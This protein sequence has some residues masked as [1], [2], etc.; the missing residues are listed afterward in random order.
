MHVAR[1]GPKPHR[2]E[3]YLASTDPDLKFELQIPKLHSGSFFPSPLEPRRRID[4]ALLA[5]VQE[6]DVLGISSRRSATSWPHWVA[7]VLVAAR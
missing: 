7:A 3:R 6:A 4:R 1:A 5:V 2:I